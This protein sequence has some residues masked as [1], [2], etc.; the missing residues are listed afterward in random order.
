MSYDE[1]K[2]AKEAVQAMRN[3]KD[4]FIADP[5]FKKF[6]YADDEPYDKQLTFA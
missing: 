4:E 1:Y 6:Y 5:E 3:L 2:K